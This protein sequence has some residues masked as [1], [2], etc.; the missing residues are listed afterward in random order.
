MPKKSDRNSHESAMESLLPEVSLEDDPEKET[1]Q[2]NSSTELQ[3]SRST[4]EKNPVTNQDLP[5][6]PSQSPSQTNAD[7]TKPASHGSEASPSTHN[8]PPPTNEQPQAADRYL[9]VLPPDRPSLKQKLGPYVS[10]EVDEAL[11]EVYL[12]LRRQRGGKASKSLIV[13]AA[14]R[15]TLNDFLQRGENSEVAKWMKMVLDE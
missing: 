12:L 8:S 7:E 13:E 10:K 9:E 11:E 14:L 2:S 4:E 5:D 6:E 15:Y 1:E 3:K